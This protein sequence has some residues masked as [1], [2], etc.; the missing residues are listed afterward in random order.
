MHS[1]F[2]SKRAARSVELKE[3]LSKGYSK[4][5]KRIEARRIS[6]EDR[7]AKEYRKWLKEQGHTDADVKTESGWK[8]LWKKN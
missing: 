5:K 8:N 1:E 4:N 7:T 3:R 2:L 6:N